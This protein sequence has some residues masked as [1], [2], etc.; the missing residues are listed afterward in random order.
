[1]FDLNAFMDQ[2]AMGPYC[3]QYK[4]HKSIA[5]EIVLT[6]GK[7]HVAATFNV[8]LNMYTD[9]TQ[10]IFQSVFINIAGILSP[11][12]GKFKIF[13]ILALVVTVCMCYLD[14]VFRSSTNALTAPRN[15]A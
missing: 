11:F 7:Q 2:S 14:T 12:V 1:M 15:I 9:N 6:G 5:G 3:L 10:I 4:L 8:H 13:K